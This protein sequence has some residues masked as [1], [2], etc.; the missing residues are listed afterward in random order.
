MSHDS[1]VAAIGAQVV[2]NG[3]QGLAAGAAAAP[4]LTGLTPAGMDEISTQAAMSFAANGAETLAELAQAHEEISRTGAA[5]V[6]VS[7]LY[8][9]LDDGAAGTLA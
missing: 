1:T 7:D 5:L 6:E 9:V 3:G 2:A 4:A 8:E